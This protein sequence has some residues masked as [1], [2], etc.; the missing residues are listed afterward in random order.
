[1][2]RI[3][4]ARKALAKLD[5]NLVCFW[6]TNPDADVDSSEKIRSGVA[7]LR[8]A[9]SGNLMIYHQDVLPHYGHVHKVTNPWWNADV[10]FILSAHQFKN[11]YFKSADVVWYLEWDVHWT[12]DIGLMLKKITPTDKKYGYGIDKLMGQ[13]ADDG[14]S[15]TNCNAW[16]S[17]SFH[18]C[19]KPS[20]VSFIDL[21]RTVHGR[22]QMVWY[23]PRLL[24]SL[25]ERV[26]NLEI[27]YCEAFAAGL[28]DYN[29]DCEIHEFREAGGEM[30]KRFGF[31]KYYGHLELPPAESREP[32]YI[33][34]PVKNCPLYAY[35]TE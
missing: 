11:E 14:V 26:N 6:W 21:N 32:G 15:R 2:A 5:Y 9:C 23:A 30:L 34:H 27:P 24:E 20:N 29:E 28:C 31:K 3:D 12:G 18:E 13:I 25:F 4:N 10:P 8:K 16:K 22:I 33:Y 7:D 19:E 35:K 17:I 1:L